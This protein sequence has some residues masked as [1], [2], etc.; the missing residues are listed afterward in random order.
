MRDRSRRHP[1]RSSKP[2]LAGMAAALGLAVLTG[3][4]NVHPAD[5]VHPVDTALAASAHK[6]TGTVFPPAPSTPPTVVLDAARPTRLTIPAIGVD[7]A[8][9]IDLGLR[10]DRAMEVPADAETVGWYTNSPTPGESGPAL[11]AAHVDWQG[12]LGVFHDLRKVKPGDQVTVER[13]DGS[14]A[15]FTVQRV[16]QHPKDR[17]PTQAVYGHVEGP[18]LRLVTCGGQFD[19]KAGSYRDNIVVYAQMTGSRHRDGSSG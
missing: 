7:A 6:P 1:S 2:R 17:F 4:D 19:R 16:E 3:I 8:G 18:E 5:D 13:A 15:S 12:R 9:I 10:A 11:L 14:A